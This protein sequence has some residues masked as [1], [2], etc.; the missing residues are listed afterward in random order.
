MKNLNRAQAAAAWLALCVCVALPL[1][2]NRIS[3]TSWPEG[4]HET[5]TS[6]FGHSFLFAPPMSA[7]AAQQNLKNSISEFKTGEEKSLPFG[8]KATFMGISQYVG[9]DYTELFVA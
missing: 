4:G 5:V 7:V 6:S 9:P 1:F 8:A 3:R 2:P